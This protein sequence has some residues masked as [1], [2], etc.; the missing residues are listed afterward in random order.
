MMSISSFFLLFILLFV[1]INSGDGEQLWAY[2]TRTWSQQLSQFSA[3]DPRLTCPME[4][5]SEEYL[6]P[7]TPE[8]SRSP[9]LS[10]EIMIN[11]SQILKSQMCPPPLEE[12]DFPFVAKQGVRDLSSL[13][14]SDD[15]PPPSP[16]QHD[17]NP[18]AP[19]PPQPEEEPPLQSQNYFDE[20][21]PPSDEDM[22]FVPPPI[23]QP[24]VYA[25]CGRFIPVQEPVFVVKKNFHEHEFEDVLEAST[26]GQKGVAS[27]I[28]DA[29]EDKVWCTSHKPLEFLFYSTETRLW[30]VDENAGHVKAKVSDLLQE[31]V[32]EL[33]ESEEDDKVIKELDKKLELFG[34][35]SYLYGIVKW[36][37][38]YLYHPEKRE[39]LNAATYLFPVAGGNVVNLKTGDLRARTHEDF[40]SFSSPEPYVPGMLDTHIYCYELLGFALGQA[41]EDKELLEFVQMEMGTFLVGQGRD[42]LLHI[43]L[44]LLGGNMKS[45]LQNLLCHVMTPVAVCKIPAELVTLGGSSCNIQDEKAKLEGK[46]L[47]IMSEPGKDAVLNTTTVK[48]LTGGEALISGA[49]K[50]KCARD[51]SPRCSVLMV[52]NTSLKWPVGDGGI[53]R[54]LL[55]ILFEKYF[56]SEGEV[57]FD[58]ND[59]NCFKERMALGLFQKWWLKLQKK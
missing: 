54:R 52:S 57:D 40:F 35:D 13:F 50:Y 29:L 3:A 33:L 25:P 15:A 30:I 20:W 14:S 28:K 12:F 10:D 7:C 22:N 51:F 26:L 59:P 56:R 34:G 36:L 39:Q 1:V 24:P 41:F 18:P 46:R 6:P 55:V 11:P 58:V 16:P 45:V 21:T 49:A 4:E 9:S 53:F 43:W 2:Q 32:I 23:T 17:D 19:S 37:S 27:F 31:K 48:E 38:V 5:S 44:G 47:V 42:H 8:M